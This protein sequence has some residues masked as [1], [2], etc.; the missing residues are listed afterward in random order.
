MER[1]LQFCLALY[2]VMV[3]IGC[4][5]GSSGVSPIDARVAGTGG[6][7]GGLGGAGG[8]APP[9]TAANDTDA[10]NPNVTATPPASPNAPPGDGGTV[11]ANIPDAGPSLTDAGPDALVKSWP[12][13]PCVGGLCSAPNVCVNLDFLFVACVPCGGSDQVC[14]PPYLASDPFH[15]TCDPGLTCASNPNFHDPPPL[16]LVKEV[17]QVPGSPPPADGGFNHQREMIP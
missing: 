15:G 10:S 13:V 8:A 7:V 1:K 9:A 6:S 11:V 17:C 3:A 4:S 2:S 16:D 12:P 5:S 14:C